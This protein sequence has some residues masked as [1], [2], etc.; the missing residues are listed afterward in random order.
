MTRRG[1]PINPAAPSTG[2]VLLTT[3]WFGTFLLDGETIRRSVLFPKDPK[4]IAERLQAIQA[5]GILPEEQ[6]AAAGLDDLEVGE[7]RLAPLGRVVANAPLLAQDHDKFGFGPDILRE[8]SLLLGR[9][10]IATVEPDRHLL[11]A[12]GSLDDLQKSTNLLLERLR[13]WY[14]LHFPE[15]VRSVPPDERRLAAAIAADP[16]RAAVAR[17]LGLAVAPAGD[18]L[19]AADSRAVQGLAESL[20]RLT[21]SR[22]ALERYLESRVAEV[23]PNLAHLVGPLVAA[24]LI[25]H[26]GGL[27]RL[28]ALSASTIQILGA[29]KAF[30]RFL[31]GEGT[32][33]K[34]GVLFQHPLVHASPLWQRG[35]IARAIAAN[36][37]LAARSDSHTHRFIAPELAARLNRRVQDIRTRFPHARTRPPGQAPAPAD[38]RRFGR[39]G[40]RGRGSQGFGQRRGPAPDRGPG[41]GSGPPR[42]QGFRRG[43]PDDPRNAPHRRRRNPGY[44]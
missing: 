11:Q 6:E 1:K 43:P 30:F 21:E 8:A 2:V 26:A 5:G 7:A 31:S 15:S 3:V 33:P 22:A 16:S 34:H 32:P 42:G 35:K 17:A 27:K 37:T 25:A 13:E 24:R 41:P 10:Q 19:G 29:E 23:A 20:L 44:R 36:V 12:V 28:G 14:G 38:P 40:F 39:G 4:A 18:D 9:Q